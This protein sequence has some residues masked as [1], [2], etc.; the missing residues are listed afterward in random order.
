MRSHGLH[1]GTNV[2]FEV[3]KALTVRIEEQASCHYKRHQ[4]DS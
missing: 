2:L 4:E 1:G 3:R